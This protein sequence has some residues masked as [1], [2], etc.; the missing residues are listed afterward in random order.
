MAL[1]WQLFSKRTRT[2]IRTKR[3][4]NVPVKERLEDIIYDDLVQIYNQLEEI[5][6]QTGTDVDI[7]DV[8]GLQ[9]AL[10]AKAPI[11][12]T[13]EID[14]VTDL[15]DALDGKAS[16]SHTHIISNV[17][18]LQIALDS[19][20]ATLVSGT[21]IKTIDE[22]SV[23]GSGNVVTK[24]GVHFPFIQSGVWFDS[25]LN[26]IA[27]VSFTLVANTVYLNLVIPIQEFTT[28]KLGM[29][30]LTAV[31]GSSV[32][33]LVA[34]EN[35][36]FIYESPS[37]SSA[38]TGLKE[39]SVAITFEKGKRY[40]IGMYSSHAVS[41]RAVPVSGLMI[42]AYDSSIIASTMERGT[43]TFGSLPTNMS[44]LGSFALSNQTAPVI[45][46]NT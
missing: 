32:R 41:V 5:S 11:I 26:A 6:E 1:S 2:K 12:H 7:S 39:V 10:N 13:H 16:S 43:A 46:F 18:G 44:G 29:V 30:V 34:D 3:P 35:G 9:D 37:M 23:L 19:K 36:D 27:K 31:A 24:F 38:T 20:Q 21:N 8:L 22:L 17:T 45:L 33:I 14:N 15:Q 28:D 4:D 42:I 25:A 40:R